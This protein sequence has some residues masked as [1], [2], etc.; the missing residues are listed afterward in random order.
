M[1]RIVL[2]FLIMIV[3]NSFLIFNLKHVKRDRW[4]K[5]EEAFAHSVIAMSGLFFVTHIPLLVLVLYQTTLAYIDTDPYSRVTT[6]VN[7]SYAMSVELAS[8]NYVF[9]TPV[10]LVFNKMFRDEFL[11]YC[12]IKKRMPSNSTATISNSV[13]MTVRHLSKF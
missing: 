4:M 1:L 7:F 3:S 6:I 10:N 2:P 12:K 11:E 5:R 8:Y 13:V 9:T